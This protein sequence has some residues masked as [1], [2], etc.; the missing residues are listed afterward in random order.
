[1]TLRT[2]ERLVVAAAAVLL[3]ALVVHVWLGKRLHAKQDALRME[4]MHLAL[5]QESYFYDHRVYVAEVGALTKRGFDPGNAT[6][7]L[8]EATKEGWSA[9]ARLTRPSVQCAMYVKHA[10]PVGPAMAE[11]KVR[12]G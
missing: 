8:R 11:G 1:M 2:I 3:T 7:E 9:V 4:L 10:A 6:I 5:A 12:C